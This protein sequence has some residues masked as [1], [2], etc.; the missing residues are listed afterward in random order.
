MNRI[1]FGF[2]A[3]RL[4]SG[5]KLVLGGVAIDYDMGL[6]GHSDGDVL[7]HAIMDGLLGAANL[8]DKGKLFPSDDPQYKNVGSLI[9][10]GKICDLLAIARWKVI[11]IDC[12]ILAQTPMISPFVT[13][14][15]NLISHALN[16]YPD[17]ISIKATTTDHLGFTGRREGIAAYSVALLEAII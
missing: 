10:L 12:T 2:D 15:K 5:R 6:E 14:M 7:T 9:F 3:H 17:N 11:N 4:V 8:G 16:I 1:G 13:E